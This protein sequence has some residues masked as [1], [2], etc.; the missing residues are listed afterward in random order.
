M[1]RDV[2]EVASSGLSKSVPYRWVS[3]IPCGTRFRGADLPV[4]KQNASRRRRS[5]VGLRKFAETFTSD[6]RL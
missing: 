5:S 2:Q 3:K 6:P 1:A 4:L